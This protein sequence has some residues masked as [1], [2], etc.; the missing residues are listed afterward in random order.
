MNRYFFIK[1]WLFLS[2]HCFHNTLANKLNRLFYELSTWVL[3]FAYVQ[4]FYADKWTIIIYI[5]KLFI[6]YSVG[7]Y[8]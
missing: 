7:R 6:T 1:N 4:I 8:T 3:L 2:I 5:I